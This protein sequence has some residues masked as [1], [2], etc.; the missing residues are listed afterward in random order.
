[1]SA[2]T[3]W[4]LYH[5]SREWVG[6]ITVT[7]RGAAVTDFT[8]AVYARGTEIAAWLTP[9]ALDGGLGVLV[10]PDSDVGQLTPGVPY[11]LAVRYAAD[12][13]DVV[14]PEVGVLRVS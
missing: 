14:L 13:E 6:P 2:A 10:G 11:Y 7:D 3:V 5:A 4:E 1:M 12:P 9:T 8:V